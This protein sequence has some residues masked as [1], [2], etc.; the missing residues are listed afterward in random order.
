MLD[1]ACSPAQGGPLLNPSEAELAKPA[2][3]SFRVELETSRGRLAVM[4]H[5]DWAPH[6]VDRFH[7]LVRNQYYDSTAFFRVIEKFVAQF[8]MAGDPRV[9][10]A[11]V[12]R[13]LPDDPVRH[14]N[15]RGTVSFASMGPGTRTAQLF[16]NLKANPKLDSLAGGFPPIGEVIEGMAVVDSLFAD[17]GEGEPRGIGPRQ[18]LIA[19]QGN[20]YLR[21]FYPRLDYVVR[22]TIS[23]EWR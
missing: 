3:D 10:D 4:A 17:Y 7:Y 18:D 20:S 2:P 14:S 13:R 21:R 8:G 22:A 23:K 19:R 9:N 15:E 6:G 5:R 12:D 11:W 1:A 16:I